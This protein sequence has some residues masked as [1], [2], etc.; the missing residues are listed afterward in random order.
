MSVGF[1]CTAEVNDAAVFFNEIAAF[2]ETAAF[3]NIK[4]GFR[5]A[6]RLFDK[7]FNHNLLF[8]FKSAG[9]FGSEQVIKD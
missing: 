7:V 9:R 3:F 6:V 1:D 4:V 8:F 5:L 2:L